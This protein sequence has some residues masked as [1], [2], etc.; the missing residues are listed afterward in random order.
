MFLY[1]G[2][3]VNVKKVVDLPLLYVRNLYTNNTEVATRRVS[4]LTDECFECI[5]IKFMTHTQTLSIVLFFEAIGII[6]TKL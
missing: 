2:Y 4:E 3:I 5:I 6:R 1:E